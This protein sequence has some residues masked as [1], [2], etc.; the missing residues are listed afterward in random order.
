MK[1]MA[2]KNII[3][4]FYSNSSVYHVIKSKWYPIFGGSQFYIYKNRKQHR[5]G[6]NSLKAAVEAVKKEIGNW[7]NSIAIL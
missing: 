7:K 3:E 4:T 6:Y 5:C 1:S 2:G